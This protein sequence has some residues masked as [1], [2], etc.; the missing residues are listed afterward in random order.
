MSDKNV[1][2]IIGCGQLGSRHLQAVSSL[3]NV[4]E[5]H[6]F[7]SFPESLELGKKRIL[8]IN[9]LN[10]K[11]E[12]HWHQSFQEGPKSAD[13]CILATQ[14][15]GR[16]EL[17]RKI[18]RHFNI[19][20]YLLEKVV[21]QNVADYESLIELQNEKNFQCWVNCKTRT[22]QVHRSIKAK[23]EPNS[24]IKFSRISGNHGLGTNGVHGVDLFQFYTNEQNIYS[25]GNRIDQKTYTSKRGGGLVD[26]TG[27][28]FGATPRGDDFILSMAPDHTI[29][30]YVSIHSS[31]GRFIIDDQYGNLIENSERTNWENKIFPIEENIAVS[32]LSKYFANDILQNGVCNLP[33]L[34]EC[35][36]SHKFIFD[37]LLPHFKNLHDE[38]LDY[39]PVT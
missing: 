33:T 8:E 25:V 32:Q 1:I 18:S 36:I 20:N 10:P 16:L 23:L 4:S 21:T 19:S 11:I 35:F 6:V 24:P 31:V 29:G 28:L 34:K 27:T 7:D 37:S 12:F 14:A 5:I 30:D 22:Y 39:C 2:F 3:V 38:K 13:L 9:D 17:V 26:L 15:P